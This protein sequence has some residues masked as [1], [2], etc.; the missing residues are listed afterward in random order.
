MSCLIRFLVLELLVV[1]AAA[2]AAP[3]RAEGIAP[4]AATIETTLASAAPSDPTICVRR[5]PE[6]VLCL[7]AE[8][9][10]HGSLHV[11]LRQA[12]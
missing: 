2:T 7:G 10:W 6:H 5:R 12:G 8:T 1:S 3:P 9:E 11:R 4:V